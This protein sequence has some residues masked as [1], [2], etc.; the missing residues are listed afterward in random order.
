M[1]L[2]PGLISIL[3]TFLVISVA[4]L[5]YGL[6]LPESSHPAA[7]LPIFVI[8]T[9]LMAK[10]QTLCHL[11][12]RVKKDYPRDEFEIVISSCLAFYLD[13]MGKETF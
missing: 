13:S 12:C 10:L 6:L 4:I 11:K 9:A 3:I 5:L 2:G 1:K 8:K 7:E